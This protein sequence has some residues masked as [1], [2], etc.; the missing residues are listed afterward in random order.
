M[1]V[2]LAKKSFD[3]CIA[4]KQNQNQS[5]EFCFFQKNNVFSIFWDPP[6]C[7]ASFCLSVCLSVSMYCFPWGNIWLKLFALIAWFK[8]WVF[9]HLSFY[10]VFFPSLS[11]FFFLFYVFHNNLLV[12]RNPSF[13]L[14]CACSQPNKPVRDSGGS[15][16]LKEVV[17]S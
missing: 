2:F 4:C 1:F 11:F 10:N 12:G 6:S 13:Y 3:I 17:S 5:P 7:P 8:M 9:F 14:C 15:G 16:G